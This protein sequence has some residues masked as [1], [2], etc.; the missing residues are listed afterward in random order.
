M[1]N[2]SFQGLFSPLEVV[3]TNNLLKIQQDQCK[4]KMSRIY[5]SS[6][7]KI[8]YLSLIALSMICIG[9]SLLKP[10]FE[11]SLLFFL[12]ITITFLLFLETIYR[13]FM[14]GWSLYIRKVWNLIDNICIFVSVVLLWIGYD[15]AGGI[16]EI[17][18]ISASTAIIIRCFVQF[19]RLALAIKRKGEQDIQVIDLNGISE[20]DE[21]PQH[22]DKNL[23]P[24]KKPAIRLANNKGYEESVDDSQ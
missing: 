7:F 5:Y 24:E 2:K 16:G 22:T 8:Y 10:Y 23:K 17:N 18:F 13:G 20:A 3:S 11:W 9:L 6:I 19:I 12:D 15:T 21:L 4:I 1:A 14:Q